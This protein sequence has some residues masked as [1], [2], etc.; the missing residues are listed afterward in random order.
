MNE[1]MRVFK[2]LLISLSCGIVLFALVVLLSVRF[3]EDS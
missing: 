2:I 1:T 3:Q